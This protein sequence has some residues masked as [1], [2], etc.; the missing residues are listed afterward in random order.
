MDGES[1]LP[2]AAP[3]PGA[4][5]RPRAS[6]R[7]ARRPRP[8]PGVEWPQVR[9]VA[10]VV[11]ADAGRLRAGRLAE[12]LGLARHAHLRAHRDRAGPSTKCAARRSRSRAKSSAARRRIATQQVV[13]GG[14]PRRLRRLQPERQGPHRRGGV[15]GASDAG[16]ARVRAADLGRGRLRASPATSRSRRCPR[17]SQQLGD[18]HEGIDEQPGSLE[19]LLELSARHEREAWAT[20][21]GRRNTRSSAGEP[22]RV[23]PSS[24]RAPK[25]PLIEIGRAQRKDDALAGL[26]RWKSAIP[27]RPRTSSRP[28]CWSTRC[29][30][31]RRPGRASASICSTCPRSC[32]RQ[33]PLDPEDEPDICE[34]YR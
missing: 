8:V 32:A 6:R 1:R 22:P 25:H 19:G 20:R 13:E 29:A 14:A 21:R 7:A 10:R 5:R 2:R 23:Q 9:E 18:R 17:A 12:D 31:A 34:D 26:E 24:R 28:T 11:Q 3:A 27:R 16:R 33:E 30:A 15:F 4:R